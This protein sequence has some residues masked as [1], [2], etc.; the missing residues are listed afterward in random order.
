[1]GDFIKEVRGGIISKPTQNSFTLDKWTAAFESVAVP[2][3]EDKNLYQVGV[4]C[5][6]KLELIREQLT[7]GSRERIRRE[8]LIKLYSS[9][10]NR[11]YTLLYKQIES[12][13]LS[14]LEKDVYA[15]E[16]MIQT[17]VTIGNSVAGNPEGTTLN[18]DGVITA[19]VE[20]LKYPLGEAVARRTDP[21]TNVLSADESIGR[22]LFMYAL[23]QYYVAVELVWEECLW[24]GWMLL[25]RPRADLFMPPSTEKER[26]RAVSHFRRYS[27]GMQTLQ[28]Y[29]RMW[30]TWLS[31]EMKQA[32]AKNRKTIR[33]TGSLDAPRLE[34]QKDPSDV[35]VNQAYRAV[36]RDFYFEEVLN[37]SLPKAAGLTVGLLID[38]WVLLMELC[39]QIRDRLVAIEDSSFSTSE[40]LYRYCPVLHVKKLKTSLE[41]ALGITREQAGQI[42][43]FLTFSSMRHEF[44][45]RP[46]V[47][48]DDE[49]VI[50]I[51]A[52]IMSA[53]LLRVAEVWMKEGGLDLGKRGHLFEREARDRLV[54]AVRG[55]KVL[56][57]AGV[58]PDSLEIGG[59][60]I[61]IIVWLKNKIIVCE[62]KCILSPSEPDEI[63]H[64]YGRLEEAAEQA[65]RKCDAARENRDAL[66]V[67]LG[68]QGMESAGFSFVPLVLINY[69]IGAGFTAGGVP[70]VDLRILEL[71]L[72]D[73]ELPRFVYISG[74]YRERTIGQAVSF[75]GSDDEASNNIESYLSDPPQLE[76]F[77]RYVKMSLVTRLPPLNESDRALLAAGFS[78]EMPTDH[79]S[80]IIPSK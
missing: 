65:K 63:Y 60:Q 25:K 18:A 45:N 4:W 73:A 56:Q 38:A 72:G 24:N 67:R 50:P 35:P 53:E 21:S 44:W 29:V 34:V 54:A 79:P 28:T 70:V 68:L 12:S 31:P 47:R 17:K 15:V 59:E 71:Y 10:A 20:A 19:L 64:Y 75:Y 39:E 26:S 58:H 3:E 51:I 55:S 61:D 8:D 52:S 16:E 27:L 13:V 7:K 74:D 80:F 6:H 5:F 42:L 77:E 49:R 62:A 43:K 2:S 78:V 46:F 66:L 32:I 69:P 22:A 30:R 41:N 11:D 48:L 14:G 23:G 36:V 37:F 9:I 57:L 40:G 1:M 33:F 76:L